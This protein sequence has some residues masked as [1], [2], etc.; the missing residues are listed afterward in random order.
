MDP[1]LLHKALLEL[2]SLAEDS[3]TESHCSATLGYDAFYVRDITYPDGSQVPP[4]ARFEKT[5]RVLNSGLRTWNEKVSLKYLCKRIWIHFFTSEAL[6][7]FIYDF[8]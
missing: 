1:S 2:E 4:G 6:F 8:I 7:D 3:P 5:W